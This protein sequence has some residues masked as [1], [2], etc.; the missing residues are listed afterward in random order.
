MSHWEKIK[1]WK[2]LNR[3]P[4]RNLYGGRVILFCVDVGRVDGYNNVLKFGDVSPQPR[5]YIIVVYTYNIVVNYS[6]F[7]LWY[8]ALNYAV[9]CNCACEVIYV[10]IYLDMFFCLFDI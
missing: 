3:L 8:D 1:R 5:R 10:C 9:I 7:F 2:Y 6:Y 4:L